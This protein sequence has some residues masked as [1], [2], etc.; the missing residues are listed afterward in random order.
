MS[1]SEQL[2]YKQRVALKEIK[3]PVILNQ[4]LLRKQINTISKLVSVV[5]NEIGDN[6]VGAEM[7]LET[8]EWL[9]KGEYIVRVI[10]Q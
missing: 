2:K 3:K 7:V 8:F 1:K 9:P 6:L 5:N 4:K 10:I